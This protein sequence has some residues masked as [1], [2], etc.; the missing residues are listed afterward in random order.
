MFTS[1]FLFVW[2]FWKALLKDI[3]NFLCHCQLAGAFE[4]KLLVTMALVY[5]IVQ[6]NGLQGLIMP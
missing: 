3:Y 5:I 6:G 4:K 1:N 2:L